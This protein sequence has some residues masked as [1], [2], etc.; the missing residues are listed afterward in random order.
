MCLCWKGGWDQYYHNSEVIEIPDELWW[1]F[2]LLTL[3]GPVLWMSVCYKWK[4]FRCSFAEEIYSFFS[5]Q[6]NPAF[7]DRGCR[8]WDLVCGRLGWMVVRPPGLCWNAPVTFPVSL[9]PKNL[10]LCFAAQNLE[11]SDLISILTWISRKNRCLDYRS[12]VQT[13]HQ[14]DEK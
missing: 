1:S 5:P 3:P 4:S 7:A 13:C 2:P 6:W 9:S 12:L 10:G 11:L 8:V 14:P